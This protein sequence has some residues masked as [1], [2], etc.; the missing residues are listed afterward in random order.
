MPCSGFGSGF[1]YSFLHHLYRLPIIKSS[2]TT[3]EI[4]I[5]VDSFAVEEER[6]R[7]L[8][9]DGIETLVHVTVVQSKLLKGFVG[10]TL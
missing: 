6:V 4:T 2:M 10:K 1:G 7:A 9:R 5:Q 8:L 3:A